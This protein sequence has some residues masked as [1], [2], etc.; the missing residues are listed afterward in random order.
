MAA[1]RAVSE[2]SNGTSIISEPRNER[3]KDPERILD[4]DPDEIVIVWIVG[5]KAPSEAVV[6]VCT[7]VT[8]RLSFP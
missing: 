2:T 8:P 4:P 3:E 6:I 5:T 1:S 7:S